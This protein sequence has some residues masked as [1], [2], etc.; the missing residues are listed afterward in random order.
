MPNRTPVLMGAGVLVALGGAAAI[1]CAGSAAA[2]GLALEVGGMIAACA[3]AASSVRRGATIED[4]R[5]KPRFFGP[6]LIALGLVAY[7][8]T[9]RAGFLDTDDWAALYLGRVMGD[10][11]AQMPDLARW[12][13]D[14]AIHLSHA[15][16]FVLFAAER[17][18]FGL[19]APGYHL[20][21]V[22][23][24]GLA[25]WCVFGISRRVVRDDLAAFFG[26]V[27]FVLHPR[28]WEIAWVAS[29]AEWTLLTICCLA[30]T[31]AY[32][33]FLD[34]GRRRDLVVS[35]AAIYAATF[36]REVALLAPFL[37]LGA[38][39]TIGR[40]KD[41]GLGPRWAV[42]PHFL[43]SAILL[44][45]LFG[46][47]LAGRPEGACAAAPAVV[48]ESVAG[49]FGAFAHT[50]F[51]KLPLALIAPIQGSGVGGLVWLNLPIA[52][53]FLAGIFFLARGVP[54]GRG[55]AWFALLFLCLGAAPV[56][57]RYP[58]G[59]FEDRH[60]IW[61]V[62]AWSIF[63]GVCLAALPGPRLVRTVVAAVVA[64][65]FFLGSSAAGRRH[66]E[67][68]AETVRS[69]HQIMALA[70]NV[71]PEGPIILLFD[72]DDSRNMVA[73]LVIAAFI[74]RPEGSVVAV[75]GAVLAGAGAGTPGRAVP[76][77]AFVLARKRD[78]RRWESVP[79]EEGSVLTGQETV[80]R[81]AFDVFQKM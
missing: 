5:P 57:F 56:L 77:R 6:A 3:A 59:G 49:R 75:R 61:M 32:L 11:H 53:L 24:F 2:W 67:A 18:V 20:V 34:H 60:L 14:R 29:R 28:L 30:G 81:S 73:S 45:H 80:Y 19:S 76:G 50:A 33:R 1:A 42:V 10:L 23:V 47:F 17:P 55:P 52:A 62:V 26:A 63:V 16:L 22:V 13:L 35:Y 66:A 70:R 44:V 25:G 58:G 65:S 78:S 40:E 71:A 54:R 68:E 4:Q 51:V 15:A 46:P 9:I 64:A 72:E 39:A 48:A 69:S 8:G 43:A 37:V 38:V 27:L 31:S 12:S 41:R 36:T 74:G 79:A 21:N 7:M